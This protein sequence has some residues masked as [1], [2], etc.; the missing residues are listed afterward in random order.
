[1]NPNTKSYSQRQHFHKLMICQ[2]AL[3]HLGTSGPLHSLLEKGWIG[4]CFS[5]TNPACLAQIGRGN[6][7]VICLHQFEPSY[8]HKV[9]L[10][11]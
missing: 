7:N 3:S 2:S 11:L 5:I 6:Q 10:F 4:A 8:L 9:L 1:M